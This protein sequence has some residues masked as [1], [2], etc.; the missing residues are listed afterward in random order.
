ML[1]L[2]AIKAGNIS[3]LELLRDSGSLPDLMEL[4][5]F[6]DRW[7][8]HEVAIFYNQLRV[9]KWLMKESGQTV[10]LAVCQSRV[11][12]IAA[13]TSNSESLRWLLLYSDQDLDL[14]CGTGSTKWFVDGVFNEDAKKILSAVIRL[15]DL[16][17]SLQ[18]LRERPAIVE[19]I[20]TTD[21]RVKRRV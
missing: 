17:Y 21:C 10:N 18:S 11:L 9:L 13:Y 14:T 16:G 4:I 6:S 1:F 20:I 7:Y 15:Q 2:D 5:E 8:P 3:E 12:P 19:E